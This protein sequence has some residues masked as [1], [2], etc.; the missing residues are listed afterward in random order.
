[1]YFL[2]QFSFVVN[3]FGAMADVE[4]NRILISSLKQSGYL[5]S[6]QVEDAFSRIFRE[7]FMPSHL[8]GL[9]YVDR[10][11]EIGNGQTISAPHMVAIMVEALDIHIGQKILEIGSGS[12]YHAA[13]VSM[14]VGE[15]SKVYSVERIH[16]LA[17]LARRNIHKVGISNTT[18]VDGD[19]S[20]GLPEHA[21]YDRIYV[22]CASPSI[23]QPLLD[24]L[25]DGGKLLIPVG[26]L[27]CELILVEKNGDLVKKTELGGCAFVPLLGKHGF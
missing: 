1:M 13:I 14:L 27:Y 19:G 24:Q 7:D 22:T 10:P 18:I 23:I 25:V 12:G 3:G 4:K 15:H 2:I 9:A 17:E 20:L 8:K 11:F 5:Q 21:P 26:R 6:K 16:D